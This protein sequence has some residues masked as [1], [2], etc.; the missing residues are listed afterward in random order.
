MSSFYD[1][2]RDV[3]GSLRVFDFFHIKQLDLAGLKHALMFTAL[4]RLKLLQPRFLLHLTRKIR[5]LLSYCEPCYHVSKQKVYIFRDVG[6]THPAY[7]NCFQL[8]LP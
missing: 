5:G 8:L 6:P 3:I 4:R 7:Y 2:F 1:M